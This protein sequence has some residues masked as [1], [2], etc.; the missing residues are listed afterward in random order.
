MKFKCNKKYNDWK[1]PPYLKRKELERKAKKKR[2]N[3]SKRIRVL[4]INK[5]GLIKVIFNLLDFAQVR[6]SSKTYIQGFSEPILVYC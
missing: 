5:Y 3:F 2:K 1:Q 6:T 4:L